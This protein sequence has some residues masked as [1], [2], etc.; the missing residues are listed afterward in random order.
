MT[1]VCWLAGALLALAASVAAP[2]APLRPTIIF[3]RLWRILMRQTQDD[4]ELTERQRELLKGNERLLSQKEIVW[5]SFHTCSQ[6]VFSP[7]PAI[8]SVNTCS[9]RRALLQALLQMLMEEGQGHVLG[10]WAEVGT[11][12]DR[13]RTLA[14]QLATVDAAYPGGLRTYITNA[15]RLL[16]TACRGE[17]PYAGYVPEVPSGV[18][19]SVAPEARAEFESYEELG[20]QTSQYTAFV[21]VAGGLGERLGYG[22]IKVPSP[23]PRSPEHMSALAAHHAHRSHACRCRY[24]WTP[25]A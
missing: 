8:A 13:K 3:Q 24:L 23:R 2:E 19:L 20:L 14:R 25:R 4:V 1:L 12:D 6:H 17:N 5:P 21:L 10:F 16:D 18:T 9:P 11:H 22:G 7:S 15:R